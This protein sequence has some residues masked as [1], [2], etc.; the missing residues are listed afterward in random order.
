MMTKLP[1]FVLETLRF[2]ANGVMQVRPDQILGTNEDPYLYR[3]FVE[4]EKTVGSI[5]IHKML[6][7][8]AD[9]EFHDHPGDNMS[10]ILS[11]KMIEHTPR[12]IFEWNP[13]DVITRKAQDKHRVEIHEPLETMWIMGPRIKEWGFWRETPEGEDFIPS[14]EFFKERGYY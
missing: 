1:D 9:I 10:I 4:K 3:W 5:Y 7:S 8:D 12:G 13:G 14:Q 2:F 11:G 6:R